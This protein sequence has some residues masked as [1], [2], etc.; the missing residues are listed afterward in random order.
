MSRSSQE[1]QATAVFI[2]QAKDGTFAPIDIISVPYARMKERTEVKE[3]VFY[4]GI[5]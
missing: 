2:Q 1:I 3:E 5:R 4:Y